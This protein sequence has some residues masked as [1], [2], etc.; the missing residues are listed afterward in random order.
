MNT[1]PFFSPCLSFPSLHSTGTPINTSINDLSNQLKF[2]GIQDFSLMM[3]QFKQ[4][5]CNTGSKSRWRYVHDR[6][7]PAIGVFSFLMRSVMMRHTQS[8]KYAN[9]ATT[10]MSLPALVRLF[11][12]KIVGRSIPATLFPHMLE[13][14]LLLLFHRRK[15]PSLFLFHRKT[16]RNIT[17]W[18][19]PCNRF[20][21]T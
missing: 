10:L 16:R 14:A 4:N 13:P 6:P 12:A 21:R 11:R 20:T 19:H 9:T 8:M 5:V 7:T 15:Q 2:L 17:P 1:A 3:N 18:N